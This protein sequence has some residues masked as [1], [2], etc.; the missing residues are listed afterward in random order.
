MLCN[1]SSNDSSHYRHQH[2]Q[3]SEDDSKPDAD[4]GNEDSAAFTSAREN[5]S[6]PEIARN[7]DQQI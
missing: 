5:F 7:D 4:D 6:H 1:N 3:D 2:D